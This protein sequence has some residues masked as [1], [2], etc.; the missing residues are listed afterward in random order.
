MEALQDLGYRFSLYGKWHASTE[1]WKPAF[2]FD[3]WLSCDIRQTNWDNQYQHSGTVRFSRDGKHDTHTS[4][5]ARI[6][7]EEAVQFT[8]DHGHLTGQYGLYGKG[9]RSFPQNLY[10]KTIDMPFIIND[11][12]WLVCGGKVRDE[13]LNLCDLFSTII[14]IAGGSI[15]HLND[16]GPG[17]SPPPSLRGNRSVE[18]RAYQI[19]RYQNARMIHDERWKL[20][21]FYTQ[22]SEAEPVKYWF[23][24]VHSLEKRDQHS[25]QAPNA[26]PLSSDPLGLISLPTKLETIQVQR[27]GP[28]PLST[29]WNPIGMNFLNQTPTTK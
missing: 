19:T 26:K 24:L 4:V 11:P 21:R 22:E 6:L 28:Y 10:R 23:D 9:N 27:F 29:A 7:V 5:Q 13:F 1:S 20:V 15:N 12:T 8:A 2:G 17:I 16:S 25:L 18:F 3:R 14:G